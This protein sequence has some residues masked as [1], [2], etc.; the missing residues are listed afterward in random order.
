MNPILIVL[1]GFLL[2]PL[3]KAK[4]ASGKFQYY[5][6][7]LEFIKGNPVLKMEILNPTTQAVKVDSFFATIL[8]NGNDVGTIEQG[9]PFTVAASKRSMVA[10]PIRVNP[11]GAATLALN[12]SK[13]KNLTFEVKGV[14]R[15]LGVDTAIIKKSSFKV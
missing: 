4:A 15:A 5:I 2:L 10:F 6:N 13:L 14:A 12:A 1:A 11:M 8:L 3:L 9:K 7:N